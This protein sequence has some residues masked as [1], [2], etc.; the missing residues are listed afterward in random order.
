M[1]LQRALV[2]LKA[3]RDKEALSQAGKA[4][5]LLGRGGADEEFLR[6]LFATA[7]A[8]EAM[9]LLWAARAN[10]AF[11]LHWVLRES[12]TTGEFIGGRR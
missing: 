6:S 7:C 3:G 10:N 11:A 2:C 5:L 12:D 9:G 1:R 8:Y 4:Q